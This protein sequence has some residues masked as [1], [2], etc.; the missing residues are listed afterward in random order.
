MGGPNNA[1]CSDFY[2]LES[3]HIKL[4]KQ[5]FKEYLLTLKRERLE[6]QN[7]M[8]VLR[9]SGDQEIGMIVTQKSLKLQLFP[10]RIR[11]K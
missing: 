1:S 8:D 10:R 3:K 6:R 11:V 7:S 2:Q 5:T 4:G 9:K